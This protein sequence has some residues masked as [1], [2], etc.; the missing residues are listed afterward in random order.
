MNSRNCNV[1]T[2]ISTCNSVK[3]RNRCFSLNYPQIYPYGA[4]VVDAL[5]SEIYLCKIL[6][7][8]SITYRK[9]NIQFLH[10]KEI[11]E[12]WGNTGCLF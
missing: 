2:G 3:I 8:I 12:F 4:N 5:A 7:D 10:Y 6:Y 9:V 11:N 1:C